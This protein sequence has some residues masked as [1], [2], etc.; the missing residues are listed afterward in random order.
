MDRDFVLVHKNA[1]QNKKKKKKKKEKEFDQYPAILTSLLVNSKDE[2][3]TC[4][5]I[6]IWQGKTVQNIALPS[7]EF[8]QRI[9]QWTS[10]SLQF[11]S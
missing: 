10:F 3:I 9:G 11:G 1:K 6:Q 5:P 8:V 7:P 4:R 2:Y